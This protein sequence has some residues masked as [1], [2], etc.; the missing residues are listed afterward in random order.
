METVV[1]K[2]SEK[3]KFVLSAGTLVSLLGGGSWLTQ[4]YFTS[5]A[6]AETLQQVKQKVE[7]MEYEYADK[8]LKNQALLYAELK[9]IN[10]RLARLEGRL[11][12]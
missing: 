6:T 3:T 8:T 4:M 12:K 9:E 11:S 1:A 5:K 2:I 10:Q 7:K